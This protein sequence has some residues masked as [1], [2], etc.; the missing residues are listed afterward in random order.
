M[1]QVLPEQSAAL[2][3]GTVREILTQKKGGVLTFS[4][5]FL[6]WSA[7]TGVCAVMQQ[8]SITF[9]VKDRRSF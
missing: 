1:H 2:F 6:I 8:I 4:F 7:S 5:L 9:D 3:G